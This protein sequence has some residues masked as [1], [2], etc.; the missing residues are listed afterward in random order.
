MKASLA[1]LPL[2]VLTACLAPAARQ[3]EQQD[4]T[5]GDPAPA[6]FVC[7]GGH[8]F[9]VTYGMQD[10]TPSVMLSLDTDEEV[11]L[12]SEPTE[13]G[14]RYGWPSDGTNYVLL[15]EGQTATV[16]LKDGSRGGAET[17]VYTGCKLQ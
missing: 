7:D 17:S 1:A 5:F 9:A 13:H 16:L 15:T 10:E 8:H 4:E 3:V 11:T 12:L 14:G 2:L 6:S